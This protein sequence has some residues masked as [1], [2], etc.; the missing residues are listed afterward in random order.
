MM[1]T[2]FRAFSGDWKTVGEAKGLY[3]VSTLGSTISIARISGPETGKEYRHV[4]K[5][6]AWSMFVL[7]KAG[8]V[9][10]TASVTIGE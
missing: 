8:T 6:L 7:S 5:I 3:W 1:G 4:P 9:G 2:I 10:S